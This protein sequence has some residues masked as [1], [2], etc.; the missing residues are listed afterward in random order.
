MRLQHLIVISFVFILLF[1][2]SGLAIDPPI[3]YWKFNETE[4]V[5]AMDEMGERHGEWV[6][7]VGW[8][9]DGKYAGAIEC[10]DDS[11]F[12]VVP[13]A[14]GIFDDVG[15]EFTIS[16]W[17][18][19]YEFTQDW[20]GIIFK[21]DRFFLER[22]NSGS[23]GTVNGI[24]FKCKDDAGGQPFNLYGDITIDDGGW[25]HIV[26]IYDVDMAYLYVNTELDKEGE[27]S[28]LPIG[29]VEDPLLIGAKYE[30]TYRNSWNGLIDDVR[31]YDFALTPEQVEELYFME[32]DSKVD[33]RSRTVQNF[34]LQQ[35]YP[36]PFNPTTT[37][38]YAI[39]KAGAVELTVF[40]LLGNEITTLVNET[41]EPG[42]HHVTFDASDLSSGVYIY[43][44][45]SSESVISKKMILMK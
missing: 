38:S 14:D 24:H 32:I 30:A 2:M 7:Q 1:S 42:V 4:G 12:I 37:I 45:K 15:T 10:Q 5:V 28:G 29:Y 34:D 31:I 19:V 21:N 33:N 23:N 43:S 17:V 39:D 25:H 27:A 36:N 6:G 20:Q 13:G 11:S 35:N 3:A 8:S 26:G 40:D 44:L 22:N 16:V 41:K 9:A 18:Q